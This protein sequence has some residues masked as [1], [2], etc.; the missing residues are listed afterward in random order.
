MAVEKTIKI[1][2]DTGDLEARI[3]GIEEAL[4]K[5]ASAQADATAETQ[6]QTDAINDQNDELKNQSKL[7]GGL[8]TA[9]KGAK[10]GVGVLGKGFKGLGLA[11][12]ATGVLLIVEGFNLLKDALMSN[13]KIM[14]Q[15][16]KVTNAVGIVMGTISEAIATAYNNVSE[17]NGGFDAMK[18]VIGS[19]MTIA[20]QP[21]IISLNTLKL[22][23]LQVQKAY[24]Q[25]FGQNDAEKIAELNTQIDETAEKIKDA[26][27]TIATEAVD[28]ASN[29]GE[30]VGEVIQGVTAI[31]DATTTAV[32]NIDTDQV[33]EDADR[34]VELRKLAE[35][36]EVNMGKIASKYADD[37]ARATAERDKE[38]Q[39]LAKRE[40]QQKI[41]DDLIKGQL[42]AEKEQLKIQLANLKAISDM[43]GLDEDR[44]AYQE[45]LTEIADKQVEINQAGYDADAENDALVQE[46]RDAEAEARNYQIDLRQIEL[47]LESELL[48][49][50]SEKIDAQKLAIAEIAGLRVADLE[51]QMIGLDAESELY[52]QLAAEKVQI[53]AEALAEI[54]TLERDSVLL[55]RD[56]RTELEE[57]VLDIATNGFDALTALSEVY[58]G[59]DE[60]RAK[61]AFDLQKRLAQGQAII[62]TYQAIVGALK[63]EGADGLL[64]FP[65]RLAN[66]IVAGVAGFA[67]VAQ[68]GATQFEGGGSSTEPNIPTAPQQAPSFNVV[69]SS[70]VNQLA[71][72][73]GSKEPVK[74]YVVGSD[75]SSQQEL[76]RK[77]ISNASFG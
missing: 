62:G 52:K 37:I 24:E 44:I 45:K 31:V 58:A 38:N 6:K 57:S 36:S 30:A 2:A 26:A 25:W 9:A 64:P 75:V 50:E 63:A 56:L 55:R 69:G 29:I 74:A 4:G 17:M 20:L 76:D 65:V 46:R 42:E 61:R 43:T 23:V 1:N 77:K 53:E 67:Q 40:E 47:D 35:Q 51:A 3:K 8:K 34:M 39:T 14:D 41:I 11:M 60:S 68:I 22:G 71:Q 33:M 16:E 73:M 19:L 54:D 13:Q 66:S 5:F 18:E 15:V 49:K 27:I 12:K 32:K 10:K 72:S 59:E 70:G 7:L 48:Y 21:L 28:I